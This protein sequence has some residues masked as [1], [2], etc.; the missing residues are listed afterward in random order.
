VILWRPQENY[1]F[2]PLCAFLKKEGSK[3]ALKML[4]KIEEMKTND[5]FIDFKI[6]LR[7]KALLKVF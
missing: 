7:Y 1:E 2:A 3:K 4:K 5:E 6:K